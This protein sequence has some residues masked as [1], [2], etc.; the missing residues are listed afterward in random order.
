VSCAARV[1]TLRR[2]GG[3]PAELPMT[4]ATMTMMK[5]T[6]TTIKQCTGEGGNNSGGNG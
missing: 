2:A 6:N 5:K 1:Q 3:P 4:T